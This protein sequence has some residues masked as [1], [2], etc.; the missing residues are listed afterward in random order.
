MSNRGDSVAFQYLR[1]EVARQMANV[2]KIFEDAKPKDI[3]L[4]TSDLESS[5]KD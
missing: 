2:Y 4:E 1:E 5:D 3:P